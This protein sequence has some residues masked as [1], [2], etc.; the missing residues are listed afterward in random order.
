MT[1]G[2]LTRAPKTL[3]DSNGAVACGTFGGAIGDVNREAFDYS[4][5]KKL[6]WPL[7]IGGKSRRLKRW[8]FVGA[9]DENVVIGAAIVHA[10]YLGTGFAYVYDRT[11]NT[12]TEKNI[13]APLARNTGFSPSPGTG[14]S[15]IRKGSHS[16]L[17]TN[18]VAE[19]VR[20]LHVD[21]GSELSCS[22]RYREPGSGVSTVC[23]QDTAG[24]HYTYKSAGLPAEGEY[25]IQGKT[26]QLTG[27]ALALLDWT[28]STP[29]RITTWNWACAV[30]RDKAGRPIGI[31]CSRGLTGGGYSQ[32]TIWLDGRPSVLSEAVF[33]YDSGD[34]TGKPWRVHT[35]DGNLDVTFQPLAERFE[36]I[37]LGLVAS[38]LHQPFG[39]FKG[40]LRVDGGML[41]VELFGFCEE[42]YAKW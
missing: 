4:G 9:I 11:T 38:R 24:F 13:K 14:V 17:A 8:Q 40:V 31:N 26:S 2:E 23:P 33:D 22:I 3:I 32:N 39:T 20:S 29:P 34:I 5:L 6:P 19:N 30:G 42:H 27:D 10:Q 35:G 18:T 12:I 28:V 16:I 25:T 1:G 41:E 7:G 21:F 36:D 15:E 37:N